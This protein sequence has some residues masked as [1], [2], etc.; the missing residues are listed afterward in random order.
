MPQDVIRV[1]KNDS[2]EILMGGFRLL[3]FGA[4]G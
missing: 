4:E 2:P 1:H 3:R